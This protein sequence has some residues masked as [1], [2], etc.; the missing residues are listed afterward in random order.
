MTNVCNYADNTTFHTCKLDLKSLITRLKHDA[1][2]AIERFESN[3][4]MLN[5]DKCH[6]LFSRHKY[7]TL[8]VN[9]GGVLIERD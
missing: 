1:A 6:F 3:Y 4:M 5:Q 2:L 9:V 7:E 8:L